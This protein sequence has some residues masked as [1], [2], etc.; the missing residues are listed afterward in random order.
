SLICQGD[1]DEP[2]MRVIA[3]SMTYCCATRLRCIALDVCR[4]L[5]YDEGFNNA[6]VPL[7]S[8]VRLLPGAVLLAFFWA[9]VAG[10]DSIEAATLIVTT[11]A[12]SGAGSLRQAMLD[13]HDEDRIQ[14]DP[15]LN[16]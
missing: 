6:P 9:A 4:P 2:L 16:G 7:L 14:F 11:T 10:S 1:V 15:A 3:L 8:P 13:A 12:D 5:I